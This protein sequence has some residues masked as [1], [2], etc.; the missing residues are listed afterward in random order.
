MTEYF[1]SCVCNAVLMNMDGPDN[2]RPTDDVVKAQ[3]LALR[4]RCQFVDLH[5]VKPNPD[6]LKRIDRAMMVRYSF[7]PLAETKDG[8]LAIAVSD[9]SQLMSLDEISFLLNRRLIIRV[10][11]LAQIE[12]ILNKIDPI[13]KETTDRPPDD[14]LAPIAPDAPVCAPREAKTRSAIKCCECYP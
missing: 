2:F 14:P 1:A 12:K 8:R 11:T 13:W 10:A 7:V 5:K 9:P 3:E 4:Y 6:I